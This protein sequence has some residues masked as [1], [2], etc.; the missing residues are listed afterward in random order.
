MAKREWT[1]WLEA[2]VT[3]DG[4]WM[5]L[6]RDGPL[7]LEALDNL[8]LYLAVAR[9]AITGQRAAALDEEGGE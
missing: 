1:C 3:A 6:F 5:A 8:A 9:D 7:T 2:P 4:V